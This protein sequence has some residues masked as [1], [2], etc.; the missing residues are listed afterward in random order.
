MFT[1][2]CTRCALQHCLLRGIGTTFFQEAERS[3]PTFSKDSTRRRASSLPSRLKIS[4]YGK[5]LTF[6]PY[7]R[8]IQGTDS[9]KDM[10]Q[11]LDSKGLLMLRT[12]AIITLVVLTMLVA[13]CMEFLIDAIPETIANHS[14]L[15]EVLIGLIVLPTVENAAEH[16]T[17]FTVATKNKL[18]LAT[19][20]AVVSSIQIGEYPGLDY[21]QI[22][23][24]IHTD[25]W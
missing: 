2:D 25:I 16:V 10:E 24:R 18:N 3:T 9:T 19:R 22:S 17:A 21:F 13:L 4:E 15:N 5:W 8:Q 11:E 1:T 12:T 7:A 6:H 14:T 23:H 20:V